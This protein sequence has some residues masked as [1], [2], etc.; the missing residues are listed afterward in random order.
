MTEKI[1]NH[2]FRTEFKT[3]EKERAAKRDWYHVNK[4]KVRNMS[5]EARERYLA[6]QK[7]YRNR[8]EVKEKTR[9]YG[10]IRKGF[11]VGMV[12]KLMAL[13]NSRCA[14]CQNILDPANPRRIHA[15]HCHDTMAPRGLLCMYCNQ[16]E[17]QIKAVGLTPH[18]YAERLAAYL[19][20]PPAKQL[21]E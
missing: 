12:D 5:P 18:E 4:G 17:G 14:I 10:R 1:L 13:Q 20:N 2:H 19:A 11:K 15:D 21:G 9:E 8:P 6:Y 16:A 7:E 3:P